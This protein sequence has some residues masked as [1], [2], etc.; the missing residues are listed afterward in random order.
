MR[1]MTGSPDI[2]FWYCDAKGHGRNQET[3]GWEAHLHSEERWR[4][5]TLRTK[6]TL[7]RTWREMAFDERW[8]CS[9]E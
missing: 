5:N 4:K 2:A 3:F 6:M 8:H 9:E 7:H 1:G